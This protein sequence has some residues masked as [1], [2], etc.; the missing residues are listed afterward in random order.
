MILIAI[1]G[2]IIAIIC[3]NNGEWGSA[4][5]VM[6]ILLLI[7]FMAGEERKDTRAWRN[8]RDYWADRDARG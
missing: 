8:R 7:T 3:A 6:V 4:A 1:F 2:G 5:V